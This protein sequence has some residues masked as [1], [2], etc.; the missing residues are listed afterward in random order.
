MTFAWWVRPCPEDLISGQRELGLTVCGPDLD[1]RAKA[2]VLFAGGERYDAEVLDE[3]PDV[4][5][6]ARTGIGYDSIDL[7]A[8]SARGILVTNTPDGP[9]TSTAEHAVALMMAVAHEITESAARLRSGTGDYIGAQRSMELS[10][11]TLGLLGFGRIGRAVATMAQA[12]GMKIIVTDPAMTST[13]ASGPRVDSAGLEVV[14]LAELFARS[15]VLSLHCPATPST[16]GLIDADALRVMKPGSILVNC[17]RGSIVSTNDLVAALESGQ[18][19]GAGLD[20][21]DPEPLEPGHRLLSM[22]NVIVTPHIASSTVAGRARMN[23][24][25]VEQ[26][27]MALRGEVPTHLLN[28]EALNHQSRAQAL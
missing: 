5:V 14:D 15:D 21:T 23:R 1:E 16:I 13:P 18:L 11:R 17:A 9:T 24:M 3:L 28:P 26:V 7:D 22:D 8:A 4:R 12:I 25:A 10:G 2:S 19:K 27:A 20:V 6:I